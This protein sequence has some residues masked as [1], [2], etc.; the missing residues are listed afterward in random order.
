MRGEICCEWRSSSILADNRFEGR[1]GNIRK[2]NF[3][4]DNYRMDI[5][6]VST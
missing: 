5:L 3:A 6:C 2:G 1:M 4:S